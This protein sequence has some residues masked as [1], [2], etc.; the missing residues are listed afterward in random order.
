MPLSLI[1]LVAALVL[2]K[3]DGRMIWAPTTRSPAKP[4][5]R[6]RSSTTAF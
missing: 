2:P 3:S 5:T 4:P 1:M 6:G